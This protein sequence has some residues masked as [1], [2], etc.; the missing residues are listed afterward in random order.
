MKPS[1]NLSHPKQVINFDQTR[2]LKLVSS[3]P[4]SS[5]SSH[6][7]PI[8]ASFPISTSHQ[9]KTS[10]EHRSVA[11]RLANAKI[12]RNSKTS[13]N[14]NAEREFQKLKAFRELI[15]TDQFMNNLEEKLGNSITINNNKLL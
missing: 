6:N 7:A 13:P 5:T 1:S 3:S 10:G 12:V 4:R 14:P 11:S 9:Q 2:R 8:R 15:Y